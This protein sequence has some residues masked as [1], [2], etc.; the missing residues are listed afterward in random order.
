VQ[1]RL[2]RG[3]FVRIAYR[4]GRRK[5]TGELEI[6]EL[7]GKRHRLFVRRGYLFACHV[8]GFWAPLGELLKAA[9]HLTDEQLKRSLEA[10]AGGASLQG[11]AL[12]EQGIVGEGAVDDALRRQADLRLERL[13]AIV[14][15]TWRFLETTPPGS[16]QLGGRPMAL[17]HWARSYLE[18]Q[19]SGPEARR[20]L[21]D[22]CMARFRLVSELAPD[23]AT[24]DDLDR[25]LCK[26]LLAPTN[27][28]E[29]LAL[30]ASTRPRVLALLYFL[31]GVGALVAG[32]QPAAPP[33]KPRVDPVKH[34][35]EVLGIAPGTPV[36]A[37]KKAYRDLVRTL[38]PDLHPGLPPVARRTLELRFAA[39]TAAYRSLTRV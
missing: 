1:G 15:G 21:G 31:A 11:R 28:A 4:L 32:G 19:L 5:L 29:L 6:V 24:L 18:A 17:V 35:H 30:R 33:P 22:L 25:R 26:L 10:M 39:V 2:R 8:E 37:I 9:G 7:G 16:V 38:H 3:D 14:A 12:V 23:E 36:P 34:A 27:L 13:A 20:L